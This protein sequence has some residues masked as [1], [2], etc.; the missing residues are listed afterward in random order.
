LGILFYKLI[1]RRVS[2]RRLTTLL[3]TLSA[4]DGL[5]IILFGALSPFVFFALILVFYIAVT[6]IRP[7]SM[8]I[9]LEMCSE[10]IGSASSVMSVCYSILGIVGAGVALPFTQGYIELVGVLVVIGALASASLWIYLLRSKI[11]VKGIKE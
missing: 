10:D 3:I 4:V 9:L 6:M 2:P 11:T 8:N 7:Y 1:A 5:G